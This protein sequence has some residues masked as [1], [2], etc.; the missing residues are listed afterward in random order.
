MKAK[1]KPPLS[2][3]T[4]PSHTKGLFK[5]FKG[6]STIKTPTTGQ[7][8]TERNSKVSRPASAQESNKSKAGNTQPKQKYMSFLKKKK[9]L[10]IEIPSSKDP[11]PVAPITTT[12]KTFKSKHLELSKEEKNKALSTKNAQRVTFDF[13]DPS[14]YP[15]QPAER[16][17]IPNHETTKYS[18]KD[19]GIVKAYAANTNQGIVR[20][21]NEDRVS[22]ILNILKPQSRENEDWPRCSFFGVYDGH[23]GSGWADF[24]RDSLHQYVIREPSFPWNPK[25][26]LRQG[27]AKAEK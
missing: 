24:L 7:S 8:L 5:A 13:D 16:I 26:A 6:L 27:F 23:G 20:D 14:S 9:N 25:E 3:S 15:L 10:E 18:V 19:N 21:Y 22:I 1:H 11:A 4:T 2:I 17:I 12:N